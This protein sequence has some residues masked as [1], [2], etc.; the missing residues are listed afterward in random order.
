MINKCTRDTVQFVT[1]VRRN[2]KHKKD[3]NTRIE[4]KKFEKKVKE[5]CF[6]IYIVV[7]AFLSI[8]IEV[9][10]WWKLHEMFVLGIRFICYVWLLRV[11][12]KFL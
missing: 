10:R 3:E 4:R 7:F 11:L 5:S 8:T 6:N 2:K 9:G 1:V 12:R